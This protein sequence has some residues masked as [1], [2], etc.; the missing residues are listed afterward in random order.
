MWLHSCLIPIFRYLFVNGVLSFLALPSR[1]FRSLY[2]INKQRSFEHR[3]ELSHGNGSIRIQYR[4]VT[5]KCEMCI[6]E[7]IN[8]DM[9]QLQCRNRDNTASLQMKTKLQIYLHMHAPMATPLYQYTWYTAHYSLTTTL[10][11][12]TTEYIH[13][14]YTAIHSIRIPGIQHP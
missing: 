6:L 5:M 11:Y 4:I 9:V 3:D 8:S 13:P 2:S 7:W 10:P 12:W 14:P 1:L